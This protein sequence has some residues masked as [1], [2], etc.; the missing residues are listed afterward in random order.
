MSSSSPNSVNNEINKLDEFI[1]SKG[2]EVDER[3]GGQIWTVPN[4]K[5]KKKKNDV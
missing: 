5:K 4:A 2:S 1:P 3:N